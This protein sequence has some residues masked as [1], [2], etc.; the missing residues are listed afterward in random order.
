MLLNKKIN[1]DGTVEIDI[2]L[3]V[4]ELHGGINQKVKKIK[5]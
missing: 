2:D 4:D 3:N 5:I 1:Q